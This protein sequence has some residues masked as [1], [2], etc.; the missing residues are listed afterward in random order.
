[1]KI[2]CFSRFAIANALELKE[3]FRQKSS[4]VDAG[5]RRFSLKIARKTEQR[6]EENEM[7]GKF[8]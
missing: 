8:P 2:I 6:T 7:S 4:P 3:S 1:M 5:F